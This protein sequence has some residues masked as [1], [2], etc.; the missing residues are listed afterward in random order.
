MICSTNLTT[1]LHED[2]GLVFGHNGPDG[3]G[4]GGEE[5]KEEEE[6]HE[7]HLDHLGHLHGGGVGRRRGRRIRGVILI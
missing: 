2:G 7:V 5:D 6:D 3:R 4:G 1:L